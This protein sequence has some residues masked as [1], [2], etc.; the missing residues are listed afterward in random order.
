M[1]DLDIGVIRDRIVRGVI[2]LG[3]RTLLV[4]VVAFVATFILTVVLEPHIFGI[5]FVVS[6]LVNFLAYFSDI[7]LSAALVQKRDMVTDDDLVT[8]FT[9]QQLLVGGLVIFALAISGP[10]ARFYN[11]SDDGL[12]LFRVI[13][14]SLF[15]AS[16]KTIPS[17]I[18][19]RRLDFNRLVIPQILETVAFYGIAVGF[20][21]SGGGLWSFTWAVLVRGIVGLVAI[22]IVSPWRVRVGINRESASVLLRFG[23]PFQMKSI[24]A[25]VKD[26][27]L[28][29]FLGKVLSFTEVGYVGWA[30]KW[31]L[32][33]L[34]LVMDNVIRV[35]F[36]AYARLQEHPERLKAAIEKSLFFIT[37]FVF[38]VLAGMASLAS[39]FIE[40]VPRYAKWEPALFSLYLF[41]INAAWASVSTPLTNALDAV[42]KISTTLKLMFMWTVMTWV[43]TP[44]LIFWFGFN[45]VS[46]ASALIATSSLVTFYLVHKIVPINVIS[47]VFPAFIASVIMGIVLY[48]VNQYFARNLITFLG[49][50]AL[51]GILYIVVVW[52]IAGRKIV[53]EVRS[54]RRNNEQS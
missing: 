54:L 20:A 2:A 48:S 4:Q 18:L 28:T 43:L 45:G 6:S 14:F 11:L 29:I 13:V 34:R 16:L 36:P 24:L 42:G 47:S 38:P 10:V 35:T 17:I 23:V 31:A 46:M 37:L 27:F 52:I 44:L 41:I 7:G 9:I 8:S 50:C 49:L 33:P 32:T 5:F 22:Y 1:E 53:I 51:G 3:S 21:Y 12:W 26:D 39:F 25:L 19:E 40:I 15:L 30:Q